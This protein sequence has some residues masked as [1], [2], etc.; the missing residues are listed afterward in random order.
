MT[1]KLASRLKANVALAA[2]VAQLAAS[3]GSAAA[4][5]GFYV[6]KADSKLFNKSSKVV[7]SRDSE[8]TAVTMVSD[9]EGEAKE[10]AVVFPVPTFIERRQIGVVEMKTIDHLD[11]FTAPRLVEYHD[12]DPCAPLPVAVTAMAP[13]GTMYRNAVRI[14]D[15]VN[16][17]GRH[18][19]GELRCR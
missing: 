9:Y 12:A 1:H 8:T 19:G 3:A 6:A 18:C 2:T 5:C 10:F 13:G 17:L 16:Y 11:A 4:F 15:S 7:L 14:A